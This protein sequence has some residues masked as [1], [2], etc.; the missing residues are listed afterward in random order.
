MVTW[1][2]RRRPFLRRHRRCGVEESAALPR[3]FNANRDEDIFKALSAAIHIL[4]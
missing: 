1:A 4:R 3:H 2:E